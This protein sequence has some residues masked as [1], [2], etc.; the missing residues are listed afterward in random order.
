MRHE[1]VPHEIAIPPPPAVRAARQRLPSASA[2]RVP[3]AGR[4]DAVA[5]ARLP[6]R[7]PAD[8][9]DQPVEIGQDDAPGYPPFAPARGRRVARLAGAP[10]PGARPFRGGHR[11]LATAPA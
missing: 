6:G 5:V 2:G 8:L 4:G 3:T 10:R 7:R 9:A 1:T 11:P